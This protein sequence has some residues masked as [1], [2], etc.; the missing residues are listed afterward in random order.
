[1]SECRHTSLTGYRGGEL[2]RCQQC[3][4]LLRQI[5]KT[6]RGVRVVTYEEVDE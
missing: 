6:A 3:H 1:M 2:W 5:I 4:R